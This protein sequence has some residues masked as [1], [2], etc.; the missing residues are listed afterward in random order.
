[1]AHSIDSINTHDLS[2]LLG[3]ADLGLWELIDDGNGLHFKFDQFLPALLG[4]GWAGLTQTWA[5]F[6]QCVHPADQPALQAVLDACLSGQREEFSG[7]YRL[8][9]ADGWVEVLWA[10]QKPTT[11]RGLVKLVGVVRKADNQSYQDAVNVRTRLML[12]SMPWCCNFWDKNFNNID[13]NEAAAKLF[14]LS[15]KQEYLD[16]F[17]E[18]SPV[19]QPNGR[20]S[21]EL[22][23]EYITKAFHEGSYIFEWMHQKLNGD[24]MPSEITLVRVK[25]EDD[26]IVIGYTRDLRELKA[27]EKELDKERVLLRT[28]LDSSPVC[29]VILVDEVVRFATP[30]AR[31]VLG[32]DINA[33][34]SDFYTDPRERGAFLHDVQTDGTINWRTVSLQGA[35]GQTKFML[36]NA[37]MAEYYEEK[38]VM[39]WFLDVTELREADERVRLM[40]DSMPLCCNF[41]DKDFRNIDCNEAAAK[42]FDLS[43]K[44]EYLDRFFELSPEHQPN[45]R[46]SSELA[47]EYITKAFNEGSHTFEWMHQKLNGEPIPAEITLVRVR[48]GNDNIVIGYTRDLRELK[49]KQLELDS[50]RQLLRKVM[51]GSP[52]CFVI[53]VDDVVRF[54]NPFAIEFL[55]TRLGGDVWE[56][57]VDQEERE[58]F[59]ADLERDGGVSW[60]VVSIQAD[61]GS[62]R[63]ML[64]NASMAEYYGEPC[65]MLWLLDVTE[66]RNTERELR[67]A[68]DAAE[69]STRAKSDF[70]AN[71]SHEIR[72]PMNAVLGMT[73]LVL[74]T[75]LTGMQRGYLEKAEQSAE[76]LLRIINDIL[77]FSKI[78]AGKLEMEQ[79]EFSLS[80]SL[81]N[82]IDTLRD[83]AVEKG[84]EFSLTIDERVPPH[85]RGDSLRLVQIMNNLLS[86]ALKFTNKGWVK[87]KVWLRERKGDTATLEFLVEDSG[88]GMDQA[89]LD[90]LFSPFT[91]AD[92]SIT[93]RYGGTGLGLAI[94]QRLVEMMGG[95]IWCESQV[96]VG[97]KFYFTA[98]FQ[99]V[100]SADGRAGNAVP[101]SAEELIAQLGSLEHVRVLL[102]EDNKINQMVL[103]AILRK[104]NLKVDLA[105]NGY[106]AIDKVQAHDYDFVFMDVQMPEMDGLSATARIRQD[107]R[108][109]DLPI[110]AMTAHAMVGDREKSLSAGMNDHLTKPIDPVEVFRVLKKWL[111]P[112]IA[113]R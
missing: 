16:R 35:D 96:G 104:V 11:A 76:V 68:R 65:V 47:L 39:S 6:W 60:R 29:F 112:K 63:E 10:A 61:D 21:S 28:I 101:T 98:N 84:L 9:G 12:D 105:N 103:K 109:R 27:K 22:A 52:V 85:L 19:Y 43:S 66:M 5:A 51:D 15:S 111:A 46:L 102:V 77:D 30:H 113:A 88:M 31:S 26:D 71:M 42:L 86:N 64:A 32:I 55:G 73:K 33:K 53:L 82:S 83:L 91:Q 50:E 67:L 40:L 72:T 79:V 1:M 74:D 108:F 90:K 17:F 18:L 107:D 20:L 62:S 54:A 58:A 92:N 56:F 23:L 99:V 57:Y 25:Y 89:S 81:H 49:A 94:C 75:Q 80:R 7:Q 45:G 8:R 3:R 4:H 97:S 100:E 110:V 2:R 95:R 106:E 37:V 59:F 70:L 41:W 34:L 87:T 78:E 13:C 69:S 24:P 38:C 93:R 48:H 44:Q 36:A 14:D